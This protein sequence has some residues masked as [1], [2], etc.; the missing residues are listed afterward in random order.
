MATRRLSVLLFA[1]KGSFEGGLMITPLPTTMSVKAG[2]VKLDKA[3][4]LTYSNKIS[5]DSMRQL[6]DGLDSVLG[7]SSGPYRRG[8]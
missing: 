4:S 1:L 5:I 7:S 3:H 8:V 2:L 6:E